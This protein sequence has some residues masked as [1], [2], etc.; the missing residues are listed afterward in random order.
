MK[1]KFLLLFMLCVV[2]GGCSN[3]PLPKK[4]ALPTKEASLIDPQNPPKAV[5]EGLGKDEL[6]TKA[7]F[8][9][10]NIENYPMEA[11]WQGFEVVINDQEPERFYTAQKGWAL[12]LER[13]NKGANI[14]KIYAVRSWGESIK[15]PEAFAFVPFFYE[16]KAG[17]SWVSPKLPILTLVS[18]RGNYEGEDA[19]KILFDFLVHNPEQTQETYTVHYTLNGHKLKLS[20]G[21]AYHFYNLSTDEYELR[22]EVVNAREIP[23]GQEVTRSSRRFKVVADEVKES[24]EN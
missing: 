14:L 20:S 19:K 13:L 7:R 1:I 15:N 21:K 8:I 11:G 6:V 23:L 24:D 9:D 16:V 17:L 3:R 12:P 10:L 18:P 5:I 22:L 2:I 4:L